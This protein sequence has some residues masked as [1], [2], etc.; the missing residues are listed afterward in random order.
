M[1]PFI[2]CHMKD[3]AK[4]VHF[5]MKSSGAQGLFFV[6]ITF[7]KGNTNLHFENGN[8]VIKIIIANL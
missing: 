5:Y 2:S 8:V 4:V 6:Q 3:N 7:E 1:L